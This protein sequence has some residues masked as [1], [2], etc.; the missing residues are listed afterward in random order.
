MIFYWNS[1]ACP[2]GWT[3]PFANE[4]CYSEVSLDFLT[5]FEAKEKCENMNAKLPEPKDLAEV[6]V[7]YEAT[8]KKSIWIGINSIDNGNV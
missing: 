8:N 6:K 1:L 3:G 7:I 4:K 2:N 5:Y